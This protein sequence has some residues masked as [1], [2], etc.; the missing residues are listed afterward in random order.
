MKSYGQKRVLAKSLWTAKPFGKPLKIVWVPTKNR[1][2]ERKIPV[3]T[4]PEK[5]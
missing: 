1:K 4:N 2:R 5:F 3:D